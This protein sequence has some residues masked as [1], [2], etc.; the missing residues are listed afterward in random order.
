MRGE[1]IVQLNFSRP[2]RGR[3]VTYS[4]LLLDEL[5]VQLDLATIALRLVRSGEI[6]SPNK[7]GQA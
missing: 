4:V 7:R 3:T 1:T 6:A 2:F 5:I